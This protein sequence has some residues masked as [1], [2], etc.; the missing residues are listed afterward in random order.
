MGESQGGSERADASADVVFR[1]LFGAV[2]L[3]LCIQRKKCCKQHSEADV[4]G[5]HFGSCVQLI[6]A[7]IGDVRVVLQVRYEQDDGH[8]MNAGRSEA[9]TAPSEST[10]PTQVDSKL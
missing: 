10:S 5:F 1:H 3:G 4:K 6:S 8:Q 2:V 9:V 7:D